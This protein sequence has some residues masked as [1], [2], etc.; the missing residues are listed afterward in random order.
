M[1]LR[2]QLLLQEAPGPFQGAA[3]TP[4]GGVVGEGGWGD[5]RG[6][7]GGAQAVPPALGGRF[8]ACRVDAPARGVAPAVKVY[9]AGTNSVQC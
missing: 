4:F 5:G 8:V 7:G 1:S 2:Q 9:L 3:G 6:N